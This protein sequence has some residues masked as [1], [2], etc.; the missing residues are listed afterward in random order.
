MAKPNPRTVYSKVS[1]NGRTVLPCE[2]RDRLGVGP[3][4][5]LRY[6]MDEH[7]VRIEN[8]TAQQEIDPFTT[9]TEW[10]SEADDEAYADL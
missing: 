5:R 7:G 3:G 6:V 9:F 1:V 10:A 2:V 4:D 8:G